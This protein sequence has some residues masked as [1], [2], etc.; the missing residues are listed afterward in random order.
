MFSRILFLTLILG[1]KLITAAD[2]D[3]CPTSRPAALFVT[4][5]EATCPL[6]TD[7]AAR[8]KS[9][10]WTHKVRCMETPDDEY[11]KPQTFCLYTRAASGSRRECSIVTTPALAE[12]LALDERTGE[13]KQSA[14]KT[15]EGLNSTLP[16]FEIRAIKGRGVGTFATSNIEVGQV[17]FTDSPIFITLRDALDLLPRTER[18]EMQWRGV[19]QLSVD[20]R[21]VFRNLSKSRGGDE[22]DDILQTNALGLS[23]GGTKGYLA[24]MPQ[25]ARINHACRPNTYYRFDEATHM[26]ELFA[27]RKIKA[28]EELSYSY[29]YSEMAHEERHQ[30]LQ[31]HWGFECTCSHCT[32]PP[33]FIAKSDDRVQQIKELEGKLSKEPRNHRRQLAIVAKLL[34]LFDE[35]GLVTPKARYC[36]IASYAA[37]QLGDEARAVKYGELARQ[38]WSILAGPKSWEV[39]RME[40]LLRDP[41]GHPSWRPI[42][43][44]VEKHSTE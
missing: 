27:L 12:K 10:P 13:E 19:L 8:S 16:A 29:G 38:H 39:Q 11:G 31:E 36:E 2:L 41:K 32:A 14:G 18:Q 30:F 15:T 4:E 35:E 22:I 24:L 25:V 40:V 5:N 34:R 23:L 33:E 42:K 9:H 44:D 17:I 37:N 26:M 20:G 28:G 21:R 43:S 3:Y 1:T 6:M 7:V